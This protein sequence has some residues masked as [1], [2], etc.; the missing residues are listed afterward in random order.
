M[1]VVFQIFLDRRI[2]ETGYK[3]RRW[4][5]LAPDRVQ[6]RALILAVF[7]S[8][9]LIPENLVYLFWG[10]PYKTATWKKKMGV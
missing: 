7:T 5:E 10:K 4:M 8:R 3:G 2:R 9:I 1:L 6:W